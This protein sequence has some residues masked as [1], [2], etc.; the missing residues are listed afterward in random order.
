MTLTLCPITSCSSRAIRVRS[1]ATAWASRC[2]RLT[3]RCRAF[4]R[5][6]R[7]SAPTSQAMT[8]GA[9]QTNAAQRSTGSR[10]IGS[11][12]TQA[13]QS[14]TPPSTSPIQDRRHS[15]RFPTV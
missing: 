2:S 4:S 6:I 7:T 11:K 10:F 9:A 13:T 14:T 1:S 8:T 15:S 3:R 12:T 5:L